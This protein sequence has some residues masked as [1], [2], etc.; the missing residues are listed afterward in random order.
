MDFLFAVGVV[1]LIM[2]AIASVTSI[3]TTWRMSMFG[4]SVG[5]QIADRLY[6]H[7]LRQN[8]LFHAEG[9]SAQL[10]KQVATEA[11]RVTNSVI[12]PLMQ[13]NARLVLALFISVAI[14]VYNPIVRSQEHT[15][16][17]QSRGH[18]V[19]LLRLVKKYVYITCFG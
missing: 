2:L 18:L 8:W 19:C 6:R 5:T 10:T 12:N 13:L 17:L 16:E 1:V 9:S 3:A 15:S 4:F 11:L 7:Y 14:F